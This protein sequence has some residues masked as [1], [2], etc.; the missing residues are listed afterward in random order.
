MIPIIIITAGMVLNGLLTK[1][2][3]LIVG[4]T[5]M[6]SAIQAFWCGTGSGT[7]RSTPRCFQ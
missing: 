7:C 6:C 3:P 1:K 2:A 5:A 4:W